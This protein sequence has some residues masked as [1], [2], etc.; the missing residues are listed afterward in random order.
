MDGL[1]RAHLTII[2]RSPGPW[3]LLG[4]LE[5]L[6]LIHLSEFLYPGYSVSENYISD[7]GVGP[8]PSSA[9]FTVAVIIFGVMAIV[10]AVMF[11]L[12]DRKSKI[13]LFLTLSG[14]GA[15]GVGVFNLDY[16]P[17]IHRASAL[18]A[19]LFGNLAALYSYKMARPPASHVFAILGLIGLVAL[20]L[21][22][23]EIYL[24]LGVGGMERMILYPAMFWA[25]GL[26]AYVL[27]PDLKKVGT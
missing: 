21:F 27:A 9:L 2:L 11:R 12:R 13:W 15:I 23:A 6:F 10:A 14:I 20:G 17:I 1:Q 19:F 18:L 3:L 26:G 7:L 4:A 22:G 16:I 8:M 5:L 25:I 24:G